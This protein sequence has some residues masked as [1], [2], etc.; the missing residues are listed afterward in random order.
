LY[1]EPWNHKI[2]GGREEYRGKI[3]Q[4]AIEFYYKDIGGLVRPAQNSLLETQMKIAAIESNGTDSHKQQFRAYGILPVIKI[5]DYG[6]SSERVFGTTIHELAHS[7]HWVFDPGAYNT[8]VWDGWLDPAIS[9]GSVNYPGPTGSS[10]RRTLESWARA[11]EISLTRIRYRRLGATNYEYR[12]RNF[13]LV[14]MGNF[15]I[16]EISNP[17]NNRFYTSA[18]WD[19]T[20]NFNQRIDFGR[21]DPNLPV[22]RVSGL[23][24]KE[25]ETAMKGSVTWNGLRDRI[26]SLYGQNAEV[27]ELFANWNGL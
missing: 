12:I 16:E 18:I 13:N 8:L 9:N 24:M 3:F 17:N 22:D 26:I 21:N 23:T 25:L 15:Q 2:R 1:D 14:S 10:A 20:E 11:V 4:A 6:N 5:K 19:M 27:T 7:A